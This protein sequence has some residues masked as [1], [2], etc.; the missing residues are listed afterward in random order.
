MGSDQKVG[1]WMI[2][3]VDNEEI[4][5]QLNR[6]LNQDRQALTAPIQLGETGRT[7]TD[8]NNMYADYRKDERNGRPQT[9][10]STREQREVDGQFRDF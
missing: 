2:V 7:S 1:V 5:G 8:S 10:A 4:T 6:Q 9:S 3:L